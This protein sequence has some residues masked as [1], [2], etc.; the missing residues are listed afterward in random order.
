MGLTQT[1]L[2]RRQAEGMIR[3]AIRRKVAPIRR[4][5]SLTR[6]ASRMA[7]LG[8]ELITQ[9]TQQAVRW[10]A[11]REGELWEDGLE[12]LAQPREPV[13]CA[14]GYVRRTP[15]QPYRTPRGYRRRRRRRQLR[16]AALTLAFAAVIMAIIR[17]GLLRF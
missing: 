3:Q 9:G 17:S 8:E 1:D 7:G 6:Q 12:P 11:G 10:W 15:V 5:L 13:I 4:E 2:L 14:D 16:A